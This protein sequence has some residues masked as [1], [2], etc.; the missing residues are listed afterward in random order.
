MA[1]RC[2]SAALPLP[3]VLLVLLLLGCQP[4]LADVQLAGTLAMAAP[5]PMC[6]APLNFSRGT[7]MQE[8]PLL[9]SFPFNNHTQ[10]CEACAR[11]P[12]CVVWNTNNNQGQCHLRAAWIPNQGPW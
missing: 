4:A 2:F 7:C 1:G 6:A 9:A 8:A 10:C 11:N 3:V 5:A 12:L